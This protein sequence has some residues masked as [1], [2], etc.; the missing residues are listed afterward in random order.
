[1]ECE[2]LQGPMISYQSLLYNTTVLYDKIN[3]IPIVYVTTIFNPLSCIFFL[4][5]GLHLK[6]LAIWPNQIPMQYFNRSKDSPVNR[7]SS[8]L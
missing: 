4:H 6:G 8:N 5:D 2:L 7:L 1:M 3:I